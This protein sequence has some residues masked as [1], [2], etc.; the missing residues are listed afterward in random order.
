VNVAAR[1]VVYPKVIE[2]AVRAELPF[3]ATEEVIMA[4]LRQGGD[5]QDLH[6][7]IRPALAWQPAEEGQAARA[8]ND[9]MDRLRA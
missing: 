6:E 5:R 2:A 1:L 8:A 3:M 7:R 9:L 4:A